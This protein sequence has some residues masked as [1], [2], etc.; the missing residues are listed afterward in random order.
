MDLKIRGVHVVEV[1]RLDVPGHD[2]GQVARRIEVPEV[3]RTDVDQRLTIPAAGGAMLIGLGPARTVDA[4][5]ESS[6][7][8]RHILIRARR[9]PKPAAA[10]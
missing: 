2:E 1:H 4:S 5:G 3:V 8:E 9:L 6:V 10:L 7:A